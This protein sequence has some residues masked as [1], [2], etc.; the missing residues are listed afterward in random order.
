MITTIN[1][2][3]KIYESKNNIVLENAQDVISFVKSESYFEHDDSDDDSVTFITRENGNVG[4]ERPGQ[5]D[6][7]EAKRLKNLIQSKFGLESEI[8]IVDEWV[9]LK[10]SLK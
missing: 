8:E 5:A 4:S 7:T 1:E 9:Y 10:I 3:R 2:F 6:I